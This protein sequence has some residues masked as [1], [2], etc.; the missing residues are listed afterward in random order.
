MS[1]VFTTGSWRPFDGQEAAFLDR[2]REFAAW[3]TGF[4]GAGRAVLAH[5]VREEGRFVS[6][7]EWNSMDAMKAWKASDEFKPR[8]GAVQQHIDKFSPTEIELV[9]EAA[10]GKVTE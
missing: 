9:A 10:E 7:I 3:A 1:V 8:M 6:F 2:W 4:P 5:D